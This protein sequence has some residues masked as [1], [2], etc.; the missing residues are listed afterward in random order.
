MLHLHLKCFTFSQM[1][2]QTR[3]LL[4]HL[5]IETSFRLSFEFVDFISILNTHIPANQIGRFAKNIGL[6][7]SVSIRVTDVKGKTNLNN[8]REN[9]Q[10]QHFSLVMIFF[11][12]I[13]RLQLFNFK[14]LLISNLYSCWETHTKKR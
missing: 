7:S 11:S 1:Y 5:C 2:S 13:N 3:I 10:L 14:E 8:R 9:Y 12:R 6:A 4:H